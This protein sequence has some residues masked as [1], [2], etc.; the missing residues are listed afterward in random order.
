MKIGRFAAIALAAVTSISFALL[1]A[2]SFAPLPYL[3]GSAR[4]ADVFGILAL[5]LIASTASMMVFKSRLSSWVGGTE[6]LW[7]IHV[8][9][10]AAGGLFLGFHVALLIALPLSLTVLFG[11][12]A[13]GSALFVWLTGSIY[14]QGARNSIF[15]H[16]LLSTGAIF[17]M[18]VHTVGAG[19]NIP[20]WLSGSALTASALVVLAF[21]SWRVAR[22]WGA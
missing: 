16:G 6:N 18:L 7:R 5:L 14:L 17:L 3:P 22:S 9:V 2:L 19:R 21:V 15:A 12:A 11:Y 13:S 1:L 10:A 8:V 4:L 20:V